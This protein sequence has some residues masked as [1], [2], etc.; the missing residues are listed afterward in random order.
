MDFNCF[1][2]WN[3]TELKCERFWTFCGPLW[4]IEA[5][6]RANAYISYRAD[7]ICVQCKQQLVLFWILLAKKVQQILHN[8]RNEKWILSV[9]GSAAPAVRGSC[10]SSIWLWNILSIFVFEILPRLYPYSSSRC[11]HL[12]SILDH[13][14]IHISVIMLFHFE[15]SRIQHSL[16]R[17]CVFC[18]FASSLTLDRLA[19]SCVEQRYR[20]FFHTIIICSVINTLT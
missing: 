13:S 8:R 4:R 14:L 12:C 18:C 16:D 17:D 9:F 5:K 20:I 15:W 6:Q 10:L 3:K 1:A 19:S 11:A 2:E 7:L